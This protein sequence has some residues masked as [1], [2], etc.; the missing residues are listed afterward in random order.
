MTIYYN[1]TEEE[2][3]DMGWVAR[4]MAPDLVQT[5]EGEIWRVASTNI[6]FTPAEH[7]TLREDCGLSLRECARWHRVSERT[8]NLW[9][10]PQKGGPP[11]KAATHL[12][13]LRGHLRYLARNEI[14]THM[15]AQSKGCNSVRLT[16]YT[17]HDYPSS[18]YAL[19]GYP[20]GA[21]NKLILLCADVIAG[22]GYFPVITY[23]DNGG[24]SPATTTEASD[25]E[26][27]M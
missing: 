23:Y 8:I 12:A 15:K 3:A 1:F 19:L 27:V 26:V 17:A 24:S 7:R 13:K 2:Y 9:E 22:A 21:H 10:A 14:A 20:H 11:A 5:D 4:K 18:K 25:H 16:R 6:I